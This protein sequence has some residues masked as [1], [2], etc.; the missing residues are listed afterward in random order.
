MCF[1]F[2]CTRSTA[3]LET[4]PQRYEFILLKVYYQIFF[5][6]AYCLF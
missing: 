2:T 1:E 5:N 3:I 6:L 4:Q